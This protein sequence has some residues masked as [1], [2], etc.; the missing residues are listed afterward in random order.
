[1]M[2]QMEAFTTALDGKG[3]HDENRKVAL[4]YEGTF[5]EN[6]TIFGYADKSPS[7]FR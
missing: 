7:L 5:P 2:R 6:F 4:Y 3:T 1:M